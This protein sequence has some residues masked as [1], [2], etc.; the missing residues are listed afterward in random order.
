MYSNWPSSL[1]KA[2]SSEWNDSSNQKEEPKYPKYQGQNRQK[3]EGDGK[4][5]LAESEG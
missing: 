3:T 4:C 2:Q 5:E 1:N